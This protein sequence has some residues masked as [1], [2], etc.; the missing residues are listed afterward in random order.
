M[1][2]IS[3][4]DFVAQ[5]LAASVAPPLPTPSQEA[6]F[7]TVSFWDDFES[8]DVD[9]GSDVGAHRW[10]AGLWYLPIP[11][12]NAIR[13][14]NSIVTLTGD[15]AIT[16]WRHDTK[17]GRSWTGGYFEARMKCTNWSAFWLFSVGHTLG[18]PV[19]STDPATWVSELDIIETDSSK[20]TFVACAVHKNSSGYG[21]IPDE[22]NRGS[23][24]NYYD[25][26][27]P[28]IGEWHTYGAKW[29]KRDI[30]WYLD[31]E[32]IFKSDSYSSTWQPMYLILSGAPGGVF[33]GKTVDPVEVQID[34][35]R[36]LT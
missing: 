1:S 32:M 10:N 13:C 5:A 30:T 28:I 35:V 17:G 20:P 6:G 31:G 2:P 16:T 26:K 12:R 34:W 15:A 4:R 33:G 19:V 7:H 21:N 23:A 29:T 18:T 11:S 3:R 25:M 24:P 36:V 8:L 9:F 27:V 14:A 22:M